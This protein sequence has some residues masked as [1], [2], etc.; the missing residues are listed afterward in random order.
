MSLYTRTLSALGAKEARAIEKR[1]QKVIKGLQ[2]ALANAHS[3][4]KLLKGMMDKAEKRHVE[5]MLI[6][7]TKLD[8]LSYQ[9]SEYAEEAKQNRILYD[10]K[11][12]DFAYSEEQRVLWMSLVEAAMRDNP[13]LKLS[14]LLKKVKMND[15]N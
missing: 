5:D 1:L 8:N 4:N 13:E 12:E 7:N 11:T 6:V 14:D 15:V 9:V 2:I 3:S 10:K